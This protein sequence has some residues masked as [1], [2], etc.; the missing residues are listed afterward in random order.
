MELVQFI[1]CI[2][3]HVSSICLFVHMCPVF[4]YL[5]PFYLEGV[6]VPGELGE[7]LLAVRVPG[8]GGE[9]LLHQ[10]VRRLGRWGGGAKKIKHIF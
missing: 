1:E 7:Q 9:G 3:P 4:V 2:C 10:H 6:E 8:E 5:S